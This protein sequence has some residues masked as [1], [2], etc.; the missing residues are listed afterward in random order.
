MEYLRKNDCSGVW[1]QRSIKVI[2]TINF[3]LIIISLIILRNS[4]ITGYE[5]SIYRSIPLFVWISLTLSIISGITIV[6]HQI[7]NKR[8]EQNSLWTIGLLLTFLCFTIFLSLFII[9]GYY[10]WSRYHFCIR[11]VYIF[12]T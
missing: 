2:S 8:Y 4:Y 12:Y 6:I 1:E 5:S 9:R 11:V 10:M 3:T 7:Y